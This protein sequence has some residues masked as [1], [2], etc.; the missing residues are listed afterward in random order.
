MRFLVLTFTNQMMPPETAA[1]ATGATIEWINKYREKGIMKD[2]FS[3]GGINGG[4]GILDVDTPEQLDEIM[5]EFPMNPFSEIKIYPL[6]DV[7]HA[8]KHMQQ[9]MQNMLNQ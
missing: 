1:Q 6:S 9:H 4:G 5:I 8:L 7:K 2:V 3:L